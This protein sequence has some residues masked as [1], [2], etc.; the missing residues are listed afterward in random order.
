MEYVYAGMF[1][2]VGLILIFRLGKEN[3][4]F[5]L[6]GAFFMLLGGWWL[7]GALT[8]LDVFNGAWGWVLRGLTA[9]VLVLCCIVFVREHKSGVEKEREEDRIREAKKTGENSS[10]S[11]DEDQIEEDGGK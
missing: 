9:V 6:A 3:K 5:Y 10:A 8:G 11:S 4:V 1:F 2:L 7:V